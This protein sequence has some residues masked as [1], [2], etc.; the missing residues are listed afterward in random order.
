MPIDTS[1]LKR[2][3]NPYFI[4][5]GSHIGNGI[6]SAIDSGFD[7]IISIELSEKYYNICK[8]KFKYNS[9][10]ALVFGDAELVLLD[11]INKIDNKI[12]FWLDGHDSGDDTAAG[13]HADPIFQELEI[14]KQH[15]IK[16]HTILIDDIRG[17]DVN[18]L[19]EKILE[20]NNDYVITFEDGYV[21]NDILVAKIT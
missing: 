18:K 8:E 6:Q 3:I 5:T 15:K 1:I 21:P 12:T 16:E 17:M 11:V 2:Y 20:I 4:E 10:I 14:I 7:D 19:K 13:L 9:K